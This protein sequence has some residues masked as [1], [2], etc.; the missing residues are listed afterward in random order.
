MPDTVPAPESVI[1][2]AS[3]IAPQPLSWLWQPWLARGGLA[4]LDGDPDAGKSTLAVD[5]AARVSRGFTP[6]AADGARAEPAGALLL[7]QDP[8]ATVLRPRL[9]AAGADLSRVLVRG[10]PGEVACETA[11]LRG[12]IERHQVALVVI[13]P[14][15]AFLERGLSLEN[16]RHA[17]QTLV[18]LQDL[19]AATG[20]CL[21]LVRRPNKSRCAPA[22]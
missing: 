1:H 11:A 10:G 16:E 21:L 13:D 6:P 9:E 14:L 5:L 12:V 15:Q 7:T 8:V 20:T 3:D 17:R 18:P 4:L 2:L 19:A 22:L